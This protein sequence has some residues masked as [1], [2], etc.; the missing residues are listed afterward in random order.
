ML[1]RSRW[2]HGRVSTVLRHDLELV[3]RT[4]AGI[5]T[6]KTSTA[7]PRRIRKTTPTRTIRRYENYVVISKEDLTALRSEKNRTG[8]GG[9]KLLQYTEDPP[10]SLTGHTISSWLSGNIKK[11]PQESIDYVLNLYRRMPSLKS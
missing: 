9:I 1:F 7:V 6:K 3:L 10:N 5:R 2:I 8:L 11:A 4:W